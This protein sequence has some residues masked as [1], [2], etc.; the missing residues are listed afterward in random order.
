MLFLPPG[1]LPDSESVALKSPAL[2]GRFF[3]TE[4]PGKPK[5]YRR[6]IIF[7]NFKLHSC[8]SKRDSL[9]ELWLPFSVNFTSACRKLTHKGYRDDRDT[10][11]V[12]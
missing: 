12:L 5:Y 6:M 8:I 7:P 10:A 11:F 2:A 9:S 3:T 4:P 1:D